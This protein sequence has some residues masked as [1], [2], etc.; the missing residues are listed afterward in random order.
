MPISARTYFLAFGIVTILGGISGFVLKHSV[1]SVVAGTVAGM[2]LIAGGQL[3]GTR[4]QIGGVAL[5]LLVSLALAGQVIPAI[6]AGRLNPGVYMVPL[7]FAG[8]AVAAV[9]LFKPEKPEK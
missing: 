4:A 8:V 5:T 7:A 1:P 6:A 2:L 9:L 3:L